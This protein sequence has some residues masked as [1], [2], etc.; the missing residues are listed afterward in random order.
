VGA[1]E[2]SRQMGYRRRSG[3]SRPVA[4]HGRAEP[5]CSAEGRTGTAAWRSRRPARWSRSACCAPQK[6]PRQPVSRHGLCHC[7]QP[8]SRSCSCVSRSRAHCNAAA[9]AVGAAQRRSGAARNATPRR[10][11]E[12]VGVRLLAQLLIDLHIAPCLP[13]H[14]HRRSLHLLAAQRSNHERLLRRGRLCALRSSARRRARRRSGGA[15]PRPARQPRALA[16]AKRAQRRACRRHGGRRADGSELH[17]LW[18]CI[19]T[20]RVSVRAHRL[21]GS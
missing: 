3:P 11:P 5:R 12:C 7:E 9:R 15:Q 17:A 18:L 2:V 21:R 19:V 4:R 14:P 13:H 10:A 8:R 20:A 6:A 1:G 16:A